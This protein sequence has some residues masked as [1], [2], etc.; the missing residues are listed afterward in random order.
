MVIGCALLK[1]GVLTFFLGLVADLLNH[2]R[3]LIEMALE[4]ILR[5]EAAQALAYMS[6]SS[7]EKETV[8]K[9]LNQRGGEKRD[10]QRRKVVKS[11]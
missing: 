8:P 10:D 7:G 2:N 4:K 5:M 11:G 9:E 3:A 6:G 1:I